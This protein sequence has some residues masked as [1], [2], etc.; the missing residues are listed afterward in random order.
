MSA[1]TSGRIPSPVRGVH[2]R[3][4]L[5]MFVSCRG[6]SGLETVK[7]WV[8]FGAMVALLTLALA[9]IGFAPIFGVFIAIVIASLIEQL[10]TQT[11]GRLL[12]ALTHR[13][14][15]GR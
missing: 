9:L 15:T 6:R 12:R 5:L 7:R 2:Y 14:R 13:S 11:P 10:R 8:P 3:H 4:G 1:G